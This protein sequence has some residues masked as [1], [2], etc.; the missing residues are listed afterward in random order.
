MVNHFLELTAKEIKT[1]VGELC[2]RRV[3]LQLQVRMSVCLFVCMCIC[4]VCLSVCAYVY[5][6]CIYIH[7][8]L[9]YV[10]LSVRVFVRLSACAYVCLSVR[11]FVSLSVLV[12]MLVTWYVSVFVVLLCIIFPLFHVHT[13]GAIQGSSILLTC[14]SSQDRKIKVCKSNSQAYCPGNRE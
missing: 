11:I 1:I 14:P 10:C 5:L 9:L 7:R 4:C 2:D 12:C 3:L 6:P 13:V 8:S